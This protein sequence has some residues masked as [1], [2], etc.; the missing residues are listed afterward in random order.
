MSVDDKDV[1]GWMTV[2]GNHIPI[3][4]GQNKEQAMLDFLSQA[5]DGSV[6]QD[7]TKDIEEGKALTRKEFAVW[8]NKIG[9]IKR[10]GFVHKGP[11]GVKYIPL[12]VEDETKRVV[13]KIA[14]TTGSYI[15]PRL[16]RVYAFKDRDTMYDFLSIFEDW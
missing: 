15:K 1:V 7:K 9:E 5:D 8:Y 10:G 3:R 13:C 14:V 11:K 2:K 6:F 12:E 4:S 16:K